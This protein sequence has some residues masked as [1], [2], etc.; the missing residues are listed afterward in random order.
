[1]SKYYRTK[2]KKRK[3][4]RLLNQLNRFN[5]SPKRKKD[6]PVEELQIIKPKKTI[7]G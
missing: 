2:N 3:K 1:M 6:E 7:E 4:T 5:N